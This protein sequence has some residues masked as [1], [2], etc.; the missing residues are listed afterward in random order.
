[1]AF[2]WDTPGLNLSARITEHM[3]TMSSAA[4][5]PWAMGVAYSIRPHIPDGV[6]SS[7]PMEMPH[8]MLTSSEWTHR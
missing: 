8:F 2:P 3:L 1:M 7:Q 5:L 6:L 4:P